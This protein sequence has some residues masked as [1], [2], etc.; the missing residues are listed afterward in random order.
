MKKFFLSQFEVDYDGI[1]TWI[2]EGVSERKKFLRPLN[3]HQLSI[4]CHQFH[5][6]GSTI[7]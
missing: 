1:D 5:A 2:P 4:V 7:I 3:E 6:K